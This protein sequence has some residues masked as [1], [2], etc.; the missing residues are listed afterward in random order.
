MP[1]SKAPKPLRTPGIRQ[2]KQTEIMGIIET[3]V[4]HLHS[5]RPSKYAKSFPENMMR[6]LPTRSRSFA[7]PSLAEDTSPLPA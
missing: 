7:G 5:K 1:Q 3:F 2:E 6:H 4:Q